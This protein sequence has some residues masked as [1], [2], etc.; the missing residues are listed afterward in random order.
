MAS[1][2]TGDLLACARR[3]Q[4]RRYLANA[5]IYLNMIGRLVIAWMWLKQA[6]V[7]IGGLEEAESEDERDFYSGKL[8]TCQYYFRYE[9]PHI[10]AEAGLLSELDETTLNMEDNWF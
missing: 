3:G 8:Q 2:T 4:I 9:L 1:T 7:A 6:I 10:E 5:H